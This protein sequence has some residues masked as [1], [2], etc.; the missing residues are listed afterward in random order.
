MLYSS[1]T[2][3]QVAHQLQTRVIRDSAAYPVQTATKGQGVNDWLVEFH[4][5]FSVPCITGCGTCV[6]DQWEYDPIFPVS[7]TLGPKSDGGELQ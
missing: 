7:I 2:G 4:I 3:I 5:P 1:A 6:P